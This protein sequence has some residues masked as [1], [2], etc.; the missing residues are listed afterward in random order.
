MPTITQVGNELAEVPFGELLRNVAQG[1]ADGQ[2]ALDL[3]AVQTLIELSKITVDL[4]PEIAEVI[5][6]APIP[7]AVPGQPPIQV[8]GAR[9]TSTAST[10]VKMSA[11]QA[12][13][14]PSFY[15]F[16]EATIQ[17]KMSIQLREVQETDTDGKK[18]AGLLAFGSNVNFRTQ[19]TFSYNVQGSSSVTAVLRPVP[20]PSR[21][22]PATVTVN[23]L[24]QPPTVTTNP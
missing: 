8:T 22:T 9:V 4:I 21:L 5:T 23:A 2:R 10:P 19:N 3:A 6:P 15:Q 13:I 24:V 7:V 17:L 11:L 18:R 20:P 16:T 12:G 1:I 14:V